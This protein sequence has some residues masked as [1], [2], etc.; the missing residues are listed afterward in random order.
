MADLLTAVRLG[1]LIPVAASL[2]L[3]GLMPAWLL[4]VMLL[5]AIGSDFLDGKVARALGTASPAGMLFDHGTDFVFVTTSLLALNFSPASPVPLLLP[6]LVCVAFTQYVVDSYFLYHDKML[7]MSALGKWN[8]IFYFGPA[9]LT[10]VERLFFEPGMN[11]VGQLIQV[12]AIA[13]CVST[14]AS[15]VD[16]AVAPLR[17]TNS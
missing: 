17:H 3:P 2:V 11:P 13:L 16:R 9:L 10:A 5:I 15:I 8:G 14:V 12:M 1:L 4:L 7:R 6:V